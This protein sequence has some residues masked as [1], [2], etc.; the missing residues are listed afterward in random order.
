MMIKAKGKKGKG[1]I[2]LD[3]ARHQRKHMTFAY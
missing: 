3:G 1:A 2:K